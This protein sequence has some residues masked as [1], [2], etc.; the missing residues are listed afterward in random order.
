MKRIHNTCTL[1]FFIFY[2]LIGFTQDLYLKSKEEN[3]KIQKDSSFVKEIAI[4]FEKS[5]EL[6]YYPIFYDTELERVSDILLFGK[7]RKRFKNIVAVRTYDE[8]VELDYITSKKIKIVEIPADVEVKLKYSISCKELM[9]FTSLHFFSYY[10]IG[11]LTYQINVPKEFKLVHN[12]IHKDLLSSYAIDSTS[13]DVSSVWNIKVV[14]RK[15]ESDPL[16]IFGIYKNMKVPMMRT[17]VMP[18]SYEKRPMD[19]MN[20][21]YTRNLASKKGIDDSVKQKI[22]ELTA[23]STDPSEIVNIIY[24]Y[25]RN[26]F[27]YVAIETGMGAFIPFTANE[28]YANKQGD[29]KD[30]SNFL[31]EALRYKGIESDIALAATFDHISD[32]DFPAL[33]SAN[34]VIGVAYIDGKTILLDPT[35]PIHY[36]GSPV[37]S[38]QDRTILIVNPKGA[39]FFKVERFSPQENE[40]LYQLDLKVDSESML[41]NGIFTVDY[42]GISSNYFK[43]YIKSEGEKKFKDFGK[44]FFDEVFGNQSISDLEVVNKPKKLHLEG[45]IAI[46]G[47]TFNDGESKYLFIDFL[48]RLIETEAREELIEG[49]YLRNP[50][51]KKMRAK[52]KM[53]EPIVTFQ[54]I[55]HTYKGEGI[56]LTMTIKAISNLEIECNYDFIFDHIFINKE[57]SSKT[58]EILK[59]FKK[60]INEPIVLKKQKS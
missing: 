19:Y 55:E 58:N 4:T 16:Q 45:T 37:Q 5:D 30:L 56:S 1:L 48:P 51:Y 26:N 59:S 21:W 3:I 13:T 11:M 49:T 43:R 2:S 57:N 39:T 10:E 27:K 34:H 7:K 40:I 35:D 42:D 60:I 36:A 31:S 8:N 46:N 50:F 22:D 52:I 24:D 6:R 33:S 9:Y 41:V 38:L 15:V 28:V 47:K 17:L 44:T 14:P 29:C 25:V 54:P 23:N 53:D 12:T 18:S 32:C 20:D